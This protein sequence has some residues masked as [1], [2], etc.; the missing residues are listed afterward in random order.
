MDSLALGDDTRPW[1]GKSW[2]LYVVQL[3]HRHYGPGRLQ[4]VSDEIGDLGIECYC[5]DDGTVFQC[6]AVASHIRGEDLYVEHRDKISS[7]V[8]KFIKNK[9]KLI[10]LLGP[11]KVRKWIFVVPRLSNRKVVA[12]CKKKAKEVLSKGLP[13]VASDFDVV[14]QNLSPYAVE[15][16]MLARVSLQSLVV[17]PE[18]PSTESVVTWIGSNVSIVKTLDGKI[19]KI[20]TL[21]TGEEKDA[22]REDVVADYLMGQDLFEK[23]RLDYKFT[24]ERVRRVHAA[25]GRT[26]VRRSKLSAHSPEDLLDLLPG[27]YRDSM[28][29][30]LEEIANSTLDTLAA[31]AIA[32]FMVNCNLNFRGP[33]TG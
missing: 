4:E 16:A 11:M 3:L 15:R 31:G 20:P 25:F 6:C 9:E 2:Q 14:I 24:Y 7:D 13:Y 8:R 17:E 1:D 18:I 23:L 12:H 19:A 26:L 33:S 21:A 30:E 27:E 10:G 22:Y 28:R 32:E 5:A 29:A